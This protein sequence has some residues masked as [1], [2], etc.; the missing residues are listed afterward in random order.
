M[1]LA[2]AALGVA[3]AAGDFLYPDFNQTQGLIFNAD[4]ATSSCL[5]EEFEPNHYGDVQSDSDKTNDEIPMQRAETID[6]YTERTVETDDHGDSRDIPTSSA[7]FGHRDN[8][9]PHPRGRCPVRVRLNPSR[10]SRA[11]SMWYHTPIPINKGF[12]TLFTFQVSDHSKECSKHKDPTFSLHMYESCAV[13]GGDGFAF[14]IQRDNNETAAI[15]AAGREL[16][17]GGI[18]NSI[19]VEFDTWYNPDTNTT[20]TGVD[21]MVDHVAIHSRST[22]KNSG[23]ES[24]SL[25]QQRPHAIGDGQVHLV[26]VV[27]LPYVATEYLA[28]FTATPNLVPFIKDYDENRRLGTLVV[29]MDEGVEKD[30]PLMAIPINLSVLLDLPQ[31]EAYAGFTA[32][33]GLKWE[34]HDVLS[35]IWCDQLGEGCQTSGNAAKFDYH[36]DSRFSAAAHVRRY[37]P[38]KGYGGT[39]SRNVPGE[40][41]PIESGSR[42]GDSTRHASPPTEPWAAPKVHR[43]EDRNEGLDAQAASMVPPLTEIRRE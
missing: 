24:A 30:I 34:K 3:G 5:D 17:Y 9:R 43:S 4:A 15:G 25:G 40:T 29:F 10:P 19:A 11:G 6:K 39:S 7:V 16:G 2:L 32:A 26:K 1:R 36:Q 38:G 37:N 20:T 14:V 28:N 12:Q 35:W 22:D 13:H 41:E 27:Y 18:E 23:A 8:F 33:T 42:P 31:D 21:M